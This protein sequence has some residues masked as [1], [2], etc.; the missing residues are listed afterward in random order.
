MLIVGGIMML[1][2]QPIWDAFGIALAVG[3]IVL[4]KLRG[5]DTVPTQKM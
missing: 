3:V 1:V 5:A 4:Q 2:P